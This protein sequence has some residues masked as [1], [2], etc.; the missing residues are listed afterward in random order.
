MTPR[1]CEGQDC[2]KDT[3]PGYNLCYDCQADLEEYQEEDRRN[4]RWIENNI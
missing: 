3:Q 4:R 2:E 1:K